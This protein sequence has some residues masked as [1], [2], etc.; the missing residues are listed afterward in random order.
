MK[1]NRLTLLLIVLAMVLFAKANAAPSK[2]RIC[3]GVANTAASIVQLRYMGASKYTL[4]NHIQNAYLT[5]KIEA[6]QY[7]TNVYSN[8]VARAFNIKKVYGKRA[9]RASALNFKMDEYS[10]CLK[11][12]NVGKVH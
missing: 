8:V 11:T 10:R 7:I 12:I 9:I 3:H 1:I 5:D 2:Y 6:N 4:G